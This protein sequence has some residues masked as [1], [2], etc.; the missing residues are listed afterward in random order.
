VSGKST[1]D[2]YPTLGQL[3]AERPARSKVFEKLGI[4]FC[5]GGKR[6]LDAA[7]AEKG[8]DP[9]TVLLILQAFEGPDATAPSSA[10]EKNWL[11]APLGELCDHIER[12]HHDYL[13][14]ELPQLAALAAKVAKAHGERH[15][16]LK[17]VER[18]FHAFREELAQHMRKEEM[19][20]FPIVRE[21]EHAESLP[22][23]HCGTVDNPIRVMEM[24]HESAGSALKQI[25]QLTGD[26]TPPKDACH[27]YADL[28]KRLAHLEQDL[29]QHVH[30]ENNILFPRAAELEKSLAAK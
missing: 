5:C 25:R 14:A 23:F 1:P 12:T 27:S 26:L 30:K 11:R 18:I 8:L 21:L 19:V 3:V 22:Q 10:L 2:S 7:C 15:P 13:R 4:D 9:H 20:L 6:T 17:Q 29:R 28:L 24:E 16:E